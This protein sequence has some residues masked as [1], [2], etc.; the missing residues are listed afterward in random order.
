MLLISPMGI[1]TEGTEEKNHAV[2]MNVHLEEAG[3]EM[4]FP[5][6]YQYLDYGLDLYAPQTTTDAQGR[7]VMAAWLR[8]PKAM[9]GKRIGMF[10]I[11]R[12]VEVQDGHIYFRVHP[13]IER[14]YTKK[15]THASQ[16]DEA[17]YRVSF[18]MQDGE[19]VCIGGYRIC[20][21]GKRIC[22]D[23]SSVFPERADFQMQS[24]TPELRDGFH[25]DVYV[26]RNLIEV[27]VNGGEYVISH[28][29]YGLTDEISASGGTRMDI[30]TLQESEP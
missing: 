4:T 29:V 1:P 5:E 6:R 15:I 28:A 22:A 20:R 8:M 3:C 12:I 26:D 14:M 25:L 24:E 13:N 21:Q 17:G 10:C 18:D 19:S 2:C 27:F 7:R 23:R 16:A 11:P 9:E 30:C